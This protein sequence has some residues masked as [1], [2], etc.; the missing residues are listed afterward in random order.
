M[1][2]TS[3]I[4]STL[5]PSICPGLRSVYDS[6]KEFGKYFAKDFMTNL[7]KY[8]FFRKTSAKASIRCKV[9]KLVDARHSSK[10]RWVTIL[11]GANST[12]L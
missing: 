5:P 2:N 8:F 1:I 7:F 10:R 9:S 12:K 4:V 3:S 6:T 11:H